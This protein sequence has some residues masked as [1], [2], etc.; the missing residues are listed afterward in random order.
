MYKT[1]WKDYCHEIWE[2]GNHTMIFPYGCYTRK[3]FENNYVIYCFSLSYGW[4]LRHLMLHLEMF[5]LVFLVMQWQ[6]QLLQSILQV[7]DKFFTKKLVDCNCSRW[8]LENI[9][10]NVCNYWRRDKG[11]LD[12]VLPIVVTICSASIK[13]L[14]DDLQKNDYIVSITIWRGWMGST[15]SHCSVLHTSYYIKLQ[16]KFKVEEIID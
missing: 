5:T 6:I 8:K 9:F 10:F 13:H 3:F 2:L 1:T 4:C 11:S 12:M 15:W 14:Y 7:N 16:Q